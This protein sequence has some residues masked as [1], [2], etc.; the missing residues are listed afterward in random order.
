MVKG[1]KIKIKW[2]N[3]IPSNKFTRWRGDSTREDIVSMYF[4]LLNSTWIFTITTCSSMTI[5]PIN[6][7]K[8]ELYAV[9]GPKLIV[10]LKMYINGKIVMKQKKKVT[11]G[12]I[13]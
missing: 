6:I 7:I 1:I 13:M 4:S 9:H 2:E 12:K 3:T 5:M 8:Y 10:K 11:K